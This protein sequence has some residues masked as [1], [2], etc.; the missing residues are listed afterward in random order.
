MTV[1]GQKKRY[2]AAFIAA[3]AASYKHWEKNIKNALFTDLQHSDPRI[4]QLYEKVVAENA[5]QTAESS[6][7]FQEDY[8][9]LNNKELLRYYVRRPKKYDL[10]PLYQP[11][12]GQIIP[13]IDENNKKKNDGYFRN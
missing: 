6:Q 9:H 11:K 4:F 2:A 3:I 5:Y 13:I 7:R 8:R 1:I 10:N 12:T